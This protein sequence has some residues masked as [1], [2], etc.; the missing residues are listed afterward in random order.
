MLRRA[1]LLRVSSSGSSVAST[2]QAANVGVTGTGAGSG[3]ATNLAGLEALLG[4]AGGGSSSGSSSGA[5]TNLAGLEALLGG[6]GG[7]SSSGSSSGTPS[8]GAQGG[9]NVSLPAKSHAERPGIWFALRTP[10]ASGHVSGFVARRQGLQ[11]RNGDEHRYR[12]RYRRKQ[13]R[14][15]QRGHEYGDRSRWLACWRWWGR[16]RRNGP[17][18]VVGGATAGTGGATPAASGH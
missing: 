10:I 12:H 3:G 11:Q 2:V 17:R 14:Q 7:G 13:Q 4:G 8:T 16:R 18:G 1:G 9:Q 6:A 15:R 5:A